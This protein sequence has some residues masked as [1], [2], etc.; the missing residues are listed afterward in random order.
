MKLIL[1]RPL[2]FIDIEST[3]TNKDTDRIIEISI[4]KLHPDGS[5]EM[6]TKRINP[7][8]PIP[9]ASTAIHGIKDEDVKD[10]PL[11]AEISK[12]LYSF[13][14]NCDI[15][16]FA[17]NRFDVPILFVEFGR[18]GIYWDY[19][20]FSMI[21]AGEIFKIKE[22]RTLAAA[23]KFYCDKDIEKAHSAEADILATV[24]V[25]AAQTDRYDLPVTV[26][27]LALFSNHDK[28]ILDL[29][30]KFSYNEAGEIVLNFKYKGERA[31]DHLDF[32]DWMYYKASFPADTRRVCEM[33]LFPPSANLSEDDG[34]EDELLF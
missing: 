14:D 18:A 13:L 25:F 1:E 26:K 32:I 24:E 19:T 21:D 11:F 29:S 12:S 23:Y 17:S 3:G 16:G 31:S 34:G 2:A 5:R 9:A 8:V 4:C 7:G 10:E 20:R 33:I 15:C 30:G 27:E 6:K 22:P 28:P